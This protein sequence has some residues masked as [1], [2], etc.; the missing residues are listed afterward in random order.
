MVRQHGSFLSIKWYQA[1]ATAREI[2]DWTEAMDYDIGN[3]ERDDG[4]QSTTAKSRQENEHEE[5][6]VSCHGKCPAN[7]K[8]Q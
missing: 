2:A 1:K 8:S 6:G 7:H 3:Y 5:A 4:E